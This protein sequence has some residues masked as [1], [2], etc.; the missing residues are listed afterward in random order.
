MWNLE[1]FFFCYLA[2]FVRQ[3]ITFQNWWFL[4]IKVTIGSTDSNFF[5]SISNSSE[6]TNWALSVS[7]VDWFD[8]NVCPLAVY[9]HLLHFHWDNLS[10][11][12]QQL[13]TATVHLNPLLFLW[14]VWRDKKKKKRIYNAL[15]TLTH[16]FSHGNI[17]TL[18]SI[19]LHLSQRQSVRSE[20]LDFYAI[21]PLKTSICANITGLSGTAVWAEMN[22]NG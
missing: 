3:Q 1:I 16:S 21:P 12:R 20:E 2:F 18:Q 10:K 6:E 7:C 8:R 19:K 13:L 17:C 14:C 4:F 9:L 11:E 5:P 22:D 15:L